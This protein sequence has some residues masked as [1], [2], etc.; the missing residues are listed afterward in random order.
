[1]QVLTKVP[2]NLHVNGFAALTAIAETPLWAYRALVMRTKRGV[3]LFAADRRLH[4]PGPL[5]RDAISILR[6]TDDAE[7][8]A[9]S[10]D[11]LTI[12]SVGAN[13]T[14]E[15]LADRMNPMPQALKQ[16]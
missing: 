9:T 12:V 16:L 15:K 8:R 13:D 14:A 6:N 4:P 7:T 2:S 3:Y 10:P 11:R 5:F 1:M